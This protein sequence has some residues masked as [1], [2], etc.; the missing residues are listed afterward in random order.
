MEN[1]TT[2]TSSPDIALWE[3][4]LLTT[5]L[6]IIILHAVLGNILVIIT[7]C[8]YKP[9]CKITN[10][11]LVSLAI[12]DTLVGAISIP[13]WIFHVFCGHSCSAVVVEMWVCTDIFTGVASILNLTAV[14]MCR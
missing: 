3:K 8:K 2:N 10:C 5:G 6:S 12:S 9:L 13:S 7:F 14:S 1:Q 4:Q 11:F